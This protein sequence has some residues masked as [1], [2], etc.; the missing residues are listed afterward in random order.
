MAGVLGPP[1]SRLSDAWGVGQNEHPLPCVWGTHGARGYNR[2]LR[3]VPEAG[4]VPE[5]SEGRPVS[6][7]ACDVLHD[8]VPWSKEANNSG[9]LGPEVSVVA[10]PPSASRCAVW[11][12]GESPTDNLDRRKG[13]VRN[14]G[15][16]I[17]PKSLG[18]VS[19]KHPSSPRA[20]LDLPDGMPNP[21]PLKPKLQPANSREERPNPHFATF[22][23]R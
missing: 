5:N 11:L 23:P 4:K 21:R 18:P 2:P 10:R 15:N 3:I 7:D 17:K 8:D 1:R 12:A 19:R 6:K 13:G 22:I 9:E 20:L 14:G 16:I